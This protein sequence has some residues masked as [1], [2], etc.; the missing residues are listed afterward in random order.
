[1]TDPDP[2]PDLFCETCQMAIYIINEQKY[3]YY[4]T[5]QHHRCE[6]SAI[7]DDSYVH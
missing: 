4:G 2:E 3:D 6:R 7:I 1:M 5:D